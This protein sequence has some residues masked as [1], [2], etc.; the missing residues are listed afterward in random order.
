MITTHPTPAAL[1]AECRAFLSSL[2]WQSWR[3]AAGNNA[4][5]MGTDWTGNG[6]RVRVNQQGAG[7][8]SDGGYIVTVTFAHYTGEGGCFH[9]EG[10]EEAPTLRE[11]YTAARDK[12]A[13]ARDAMMRLELPPVPMMPEEAALARVAEDAKAAAFWADGDDA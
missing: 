11:A 3:A 5:A 7:D 1:L 12:Y 6:M 13:R 2:H 8:F 9:I 10:R 4:E